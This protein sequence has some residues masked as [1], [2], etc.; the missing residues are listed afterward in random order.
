MSNGPA[1][2]SDIG[3]QYVLLVNSETLDTVETLLLTPDDVGVYTYNFTNVAPGNYA[4]FSGTDS[5]NDDFVCDGGETCGSYPTLDRISTLSVNSDLANLDFVTG[6]D[7]AVNPAS[8]SQNGG[9]LPSSGFALK[10]VKKNLSV[11]E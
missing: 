4:I 6:Y 8:A 10:I 7:A 11:A 2:A 5:D 3:T 1:R 9:P